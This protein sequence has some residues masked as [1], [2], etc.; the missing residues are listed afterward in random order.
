MLN[1]EFIKSESSVKHNNREYFD[2]SESTT[3]R[4]KS[5]IGDR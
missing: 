3:F 4:S 1:S 2:Y 5:R